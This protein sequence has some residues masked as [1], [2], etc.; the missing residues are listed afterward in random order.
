MNL[1]LVSRMLGLISLLI[2][3]MMIF[4][5]PWAHPTLGNRA[6][7]EAE[8]SFEWRGFLALLGSILISGAVGGLLL[9]LSRYERGRLFRKEA[10]AVV[11]LS[12][13]LATILDALP[14]WLCGIYRSPAVRHPAG[15]SQQ[16]WQLFNYRTLSWRQWISKPPV[17]SDQQRVLEALKKAGARGLSAQ[18]LSAEA[19][20]ADPE[21]HIRELVDRDPDWRLCIL[22][23]DPSA[24]D[25]SREHNYRF[26]WIRMTLVDALFESQSGFS[27]TGATVLADLEDPELVPHCLLFWRSSTQFLGGLGIIVLFV[28]ILGQGSAGKALVRAEM[29]GPSKEGITA[30]MQETALAFTA[31]Y[32]GLNGILTILLW[33]QGLSWFDA[34]CHTFAT[35]STGGFSTWNASV[36]HFQSALIDYTITIFMLIGGT[37]FLLIYLLIIGQP[38]RL[39]LD[40]EWQTY[41]V[42]VLGISALVVAFGLVTND[43]TGE[44]FGARLLNGI[45]YGLFQV[46]SVITTTGF[47]THDFDR[48]NSFGRGALF[49]LMFVGGCAGST[50]GGLKVIRH[51]LFFKIMRQ[52][53]EKSFHPNV[54]RPL[55][56]GGK[57]LEDSE[58]SRNIM[59]YFCLILVIFV[60]SW[61]FIV[62]VEPDSTWG[63]QIEHKL[64]DSAT[65]IAAT[66]NNVGP[67]LGTVGA[68]QN[69]GHFS[70]LTKLLF[71]GLMMLGRLELFVILVLFMP[72]FW[73]CYG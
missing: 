33:L 41:L 21:M 25:S 55:R 66:L 68:T 16:E 46:V 4:S 56:L 19:G 64:I 73:R 67:G 57:A 28:A 59:V 10:M 15:A 17:D 50:A 8:L 63:S 36:G 44:S 11:G 62:T 27:T 39:F 48:W 12:W 29:P 5:L 45:R 22:F 1:R 37:N 35:M 54:M 40:L 65:G 60:L 43:F 18:Q 42:V 6:E 38:K 24:S 7:L 14:F 71:V 13:V 2:G 32:C 31:I 20:L 51:L 58:L 23:P 70:A 9:W 72:R 61:G 30:R 3:G 53:I 49:L 69:Y 47:G 52:E 34:I 26:R